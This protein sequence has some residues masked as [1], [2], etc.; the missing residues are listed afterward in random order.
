[1]DAK[2]GPQIIEYASKSLNF[3]PYDVKWVPSRSGEQARDCINSHCVR[4][5]CSSKL[6]VS[7]IAPNGKGVIQIFQ[8]KEGQLQLVT[9][10]YF[11]VF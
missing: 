11:I 9:E 6:A 10:V 1:M 5:C 4:L 8:M 2:S 3:T 7:G